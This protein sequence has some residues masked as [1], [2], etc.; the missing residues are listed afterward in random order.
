MKIEKLAR[1]R[2]LIIVPALL[3]LVLAACG[4]PPADSGAAEEE[5]PAPEEGATDDEGA[6]EEEAPA[7]VE[8][9]APGRPVEFVVTTSPGGGSDQYARF[10][11]GV[12]EQQDLSPVPFVVVNQPGGA[13]AVGMQYLYEKAGEGNAVLITLNSVF[14]TP[15]L[16]G[17]PFQSMADDF[18]PVSSMALDPF[19]LWTNADGWETYEEFA[20]E[21]ATRQVSSGGTGSKQEDEVLLNL[22]QRAAGLEPFSY[23][24]FEGG[25][26]VA[27]EVA[28]GHIEISVNQPSE[29]APHVPDRM[30]P[31]VVFSEE[32]L[33]DFPDVPTYAEVGLD[34]HPELDYIMIRGIVGPP[35]MPPENRAWMQDLFHQVFDS[36]DWQDF[37]ATNQMV[38]DYIEGDEFGEFLRTYDE[39]HADLITELGWEAEES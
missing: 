18:T 38:G 35:D 24:P 23:V 12:V 3:L 39:L 6:T 32:R 13:G 2:L 8:A 15:V 9:E 29:A 36:E 30:R 5:E 21:A 4:S 28:G 16:Q 25:G 26:D 33:P 19:V 22:L 31:L 37:L 7:E 20:E 1:L 17:L 11:A 14:T 10:I 27:A 34:D